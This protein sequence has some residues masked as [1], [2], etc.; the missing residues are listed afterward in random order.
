VF[1]HEPLRNRL[2]HNHTLLLVVGRPELD[3][4]LLHRHGRHLDLDLDL[5]F[6]LDLDDFGD[7]DLYFLR[8]LDLDFLLDHHRLFD[9]LWS[10]GG[11]AGSHKAEQDGH[12]NG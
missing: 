2:V 10:R 11:A 12:D 6:L 5:D 1:G 8:D 7:L 3:D 4:G 9:H